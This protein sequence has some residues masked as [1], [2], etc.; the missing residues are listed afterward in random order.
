MSLP[1]VKTTI[2]DRFVDDFTGSHRVFISKKAM[3]SVRRIAVITDPDKVLQEVEKLKENLGFMEKYPGIYP[4]PEIYQEMIKNQ[5]TSDFI[6]AFK[7]WKTN[8]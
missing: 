1:G 8:L 5:Q 3:Q 7:E 6:E 4:D 2:I